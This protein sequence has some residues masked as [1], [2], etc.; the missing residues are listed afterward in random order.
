[1]EKL[2]SVSAVNSQFCAECPKD[3]KIAAALASSR[4]LQDRAV[5]ENIYLHINYPVGKVKVFFMGITETR[6]CTAYLRCMRSGSV[7]TQTLPTGLK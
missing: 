1:M 5:G 2:H 6:D 4:H 3:H 7:R